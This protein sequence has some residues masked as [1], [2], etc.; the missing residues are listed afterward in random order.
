[1]NLA[2][3]TELTPNCFLLCS[4]W[5]PE[6]NKSCLHLYLS[7]TTLL[8]VCTSMCTCVHTCVS[9]KDRVSLKYFPSGVIRLGPFGLVWF[10]RQGSRW[11]E[12]DL[13]DWSVSPV[14]HCLC[15]FSAG[16]EYTPPHPAFS[17]YVG[18][19]DRLILPKRELHLL[20]CLPGPTLHVSVRSSPV[21]T[22]FIPPQYTISTYLIREKTRFGMC[23][24]TKGLVTENGGEGLPTLEVCLKLAQRGV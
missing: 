23:L 8:C 13:G 4:V 6:H 1:M 16:I 21:H 12:A 7:P 24:H 17:F 2:A 10:L 20:V 15:L 22:N 19:G 3:S 14:V 9:A 5:T 18:S 11:P